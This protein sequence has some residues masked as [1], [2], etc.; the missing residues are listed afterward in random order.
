MIKMT[1][2]RV[3]VVL[4]IGLILVTSIFSGC[5]SDISDKKLYGDEISGK[6]LRVCLDCW[7]MDPTTSSDAAQHEYDTNLYLQGLAAE[8]K[9]ACNIEKFVFEVL[10]QSGVERETILQRLRTEIM[11]GGGPDLFIMDT[12]LEPMDYERAI[13][14]DAMPLINFP[15]KSMEIGL[16]LPLDEYMENHTQFTDWN[17]QTK[18]VMDAGRN[19][20]GQLIIPL[21]YTLPIFIYPKSAIDPSISEMTMWDILEDPDTS[22]FGA[23]LYSLIGRKEAD[24]LDTPFVLGKFADYQTE[25]LLFTE[26]ELYKV[27]ETSYNLQ[28]EAENIQLQYFE[29]EASLHGVF[30]KINLEY[31]DAEMTL[32][33]VYSMNGGVV[34]SVE[35][36]AAVNR[37]TK[38][39]KEAF[40][41][42]DYIMQEDMQRSSDF[43]YN[44][45][46][47][48]LPMQ[49]DLGQ[50]GKS[51]NATSNPESILPQPYFEDLLTIKE[52]I[53]AVNFQGRLDS[54]LRELM[55]EIQID[56]TINGNKPRREDVA[57]AYEQMKRMIGE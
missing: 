18:A 27:I 50:E 30:H 42:I 52:Q 25:Q 28:D 6:T 15:E 2:K 26:D 1:S 12:K 39:P 44:Y 35:S 10:P 40:S 22:E 3:T 24:G 20:E 19:E 5:R 56:V 13:G 8:I 47:D 11:S 57:A 49:N 37:N 45:F 54:I 33:P 41:V 46:S 32:V 7:R 9:K 53:T 31:F 23:A 21:T 4:L 43:Y 17:N 36:Y 38:F 48:G 55:T 34:A 16:F 14:E 51:L 29:S